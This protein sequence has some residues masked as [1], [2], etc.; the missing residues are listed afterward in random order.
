M[1]VYLYGCMGRNG[2]GVVSSAAWR[3]L[4]VINTKE[5]RL[6]ADL[7]RKKKI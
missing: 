1:F 5:L 2:R 7:Q 6:S 4:A 3:V